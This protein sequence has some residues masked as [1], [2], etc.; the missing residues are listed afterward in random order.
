[1]RPSLWEMAVLD[2]SLSRTG[3]VF[4]Q[5]CTRVFSFRRG[6]EQ[7]LSNR[8]TA[9]WVKLKKINQPQPK[10]PQQSVKGFLLYVVLL[11]FSLGLSPLSSLTVEA[12]DL[13][14]FLLSLNHQKPKEKPNISSLSLFKISFGFL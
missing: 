12:P 5:R 14:L 7:G 6:V 10:D 2:R 8:E 1:M 13:F 11:P 9:V 3:L 4:S